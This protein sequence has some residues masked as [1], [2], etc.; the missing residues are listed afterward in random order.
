MLVCDLVSGKNLYFW[1]KMQWC[2][3]KEEDLHIG[4]QFGELSELL[5]VKSLSQGNCWEWESFEQDGGKRLG[6]GNGQGKSLGQYL[7]HGKILTL[8]NG[9][10]KTLGQGRAHRGDGMW[11]EVLMKFRGNINTAKTCPGE[12][13]RKNS[14]R[15][16][17]SRGRGTFL[18]YGGT[19][20]S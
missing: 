12:Y 19:E 17:M 14:V 5:E 4:V 1:H 7:G 10:K 15:W 11:M 6:Q 9:L 13:E 8:V 2:M 20:K 3:V 16:G 18:D